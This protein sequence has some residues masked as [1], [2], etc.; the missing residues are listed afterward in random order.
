MIVVPSANEAVSVRDDDTDST[1]IQENSAPSSGVVEKVNVEIVLVEPTQGDSVQG[2]DANSPARSHA[3]SAS[4]QAETS[5]RKDRNA[6]TQSTESASGSSP[7]LEVTVSL[8]STSA[9]NDLPG[10]T[11]TKTSPQGGSSTVAKDSSASIQ[12][13]TLPRA[14]AAPATKAGTVISGTKDADKDK[15]KKSSSWIP[16]I[17]RSKDSKK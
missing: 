4:K 9:N 8:D 14:P 17:F 12:S 16:S 3:D 6:P 7:A 11:L 5:S 13:S 15:K 10:V 2:L 1:R